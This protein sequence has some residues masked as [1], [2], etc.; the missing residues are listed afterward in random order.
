MRCMTEWGVDVRRIGRTDKE[1]LDQ[2]KA[3][4]AYYWADRDTRPK[5]DDELHARLCHDGFRVSRDAVQHLRVEMNL[6]RRWDAKLGRV[7]PDEELGKRTR[8]RRQKHSAF[9]HAQLVP[10][11]DGG[12][13]DDDD[14]DDDD[15]SNNNN[16]YNGDDSPDRD[17]DDDDGQDDESE[18]SPQLQPVEPTRDGCYSGPALPKP[19][20]SRRRTYGGQQK[21]KSARPS[22]PQQVARPAQPYLSISAQAA[23]Y[24]YMAPQQVTQPSS[25][26]SNAAKDV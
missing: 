26:L 2:L 7:R 16:N 10:P 1:S 8:R 21:A 9:T 6:F 15:N 13:D 23:P 3:R 12:G 11:R 5:T 22:R 20:S 17:N 25:T 24:P 14:D 18:S 19:A 4:I